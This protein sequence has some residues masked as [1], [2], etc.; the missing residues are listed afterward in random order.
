MCACFSFFFYTGANQ[1]R[2]VMTCTRLFVC[3]CTFIYAIC[4]LA[5]RREG[6]RVGARIC[7]LLFVCFYFACALPLCV[8]FSGCVLPLAQHSL[9]QQ[10]RQ[11]KDHYDSVSIVWQFQECLAFCQAFI[12]GRTHWRAASTKYFI[13]SCIQ[14]YVYICMYVCMYYA[15]RTW[16]IFIFCSFSVAVLTNN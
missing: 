15:L 9:Q 16:D 1:K 14:T 5:K 2:K 13:A 6:V 3:V 10:Q 4:V 8:C 12:C 7:E 11:Q